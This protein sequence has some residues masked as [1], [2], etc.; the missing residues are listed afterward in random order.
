MKKPFYGLDFGTSN[1][2]ISIADGSKATILPVDTYAPLSEVLQSLLYFQKDSSEFIGQTAVDTY[3]Q[4]NAIRRPVQWQE[5]DTG[6]EKQVEIAGD[7]G[8]VYYTTTI[9]VRVDINKPGQLLQALKTTLREGSLETAYV[10]D[11]KYS[12]EALIARLLSQMKREADKVVGEDV[13][14][15]VLGRPVHY[16]EAGQDDVHVEGRMRKAAQL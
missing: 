10:F 2:V 6:E 1:S 3:L 14:R 9:K 7:N 12:L 5:I 11:K 15:V 13:K 16:I 4:D 8:I